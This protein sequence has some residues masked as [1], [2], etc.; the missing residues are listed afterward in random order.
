MGKR[1]LEGVKVLELATFVAAPCCARYLAELGADVIKVET[2]RGDNLRYT[3]L[4][5][6]RPFGDMED[7]TYAQENGS[8]RAVIV[9]IKSEAGHDAFLKLV[10]WCD[11]FVTNL[12]PG[13]LQRAGIDYETL[14]ER[15]PALVMGLVSGQ[16]ELGPEKDI[17]G[18]DFT[19]Y[20]AR[21][22]VMGALFDRE[23]SPMLPCAGFGDHQVGMAL[24]AGLMAA[25]L[26]ARETGEG[27]QVTVSLLQMGLFDVSLNLTASQYGDPGMQYPVARK[28]IANQLQLPHKTKDGRWFMIAIPPYDLLFNKFIAAIGREDLVDDERFYPQK[29]ALNHLPELHDIIAAE[30]IKKTAAEWEAIFK[31]ADLPAAKCFTWAELLED[32]QCWANDYLVSVD[33]P[34]GNKRTIVHS[35]N[36]FANTTL[37]PITRAPFLGEHT[38]EVMVELGYSEEEIAG[39]LEAGDINDVVRIG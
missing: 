33:F 16:G 31:E 27:D 30:F 12:R 38:I 25:L 22:G 29:N 4:N 15:K 10:D 5:E 37:A 3:A 6:G 20:F 34:S 24:A 32:E 28:E 36:T 26:K 1:P 23:G 39:M 2:K 13:A 21:S 35:P 18:Y 14:K 19:S 9:N 7:T 11:I 8:K 17:P